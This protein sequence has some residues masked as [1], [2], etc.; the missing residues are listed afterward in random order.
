MRSLLKFLLVLLFSV[1]T[2]SVSDAQTAA[3][4]STSMQ[5]D[6]LNRLTNIWSPDGFRETFQYDPVGNMILH[7]RFGPPRISSLS[8]NVVLIGG[9]GR[10]RFIVAHSILPISNILVSATSSNPKIFGTNTVLI[11][12]SGTNRAV[13]VR[14]L[15]GAFG[16]TTIHLVATDG[17]IGSTN[18]FTLEIRP[19]E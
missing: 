13:E 9:D 18:S 2:F 5:Y 17:F 4:R 12:G 3:T 6:A 1:T 16:K 15:D 19:E 14:P 8:S 7:Q 11:S 10:V